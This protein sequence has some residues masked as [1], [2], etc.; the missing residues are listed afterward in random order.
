MEE[1]KD[2]WHSQLMRVIFIGLAS[3]AMLIPLEM[4]RSQIR[5]RERSHDEAIYDIT[6]SWGTTQTLNGPFITYKYLK[7]KNQSKEFETAAGTLFPD[8]L[9]YTVNTTSKELHRSIYDVQVYTADITVEGNFILEG[10]IVSSESTELALELLDLKGIQGNPEFTFNGKP[11]KIKANGNTITA[12]VKIPAGAAEGDSF[13]FC[14][15]IKINGSDALYFKPIGNLTT[16]D[17]TSDY[18]D[19]SFSGDFLPLERDV[20]EDGFTAKWEVSQITLASPSTD[21]FGVRLVKPVTQYRQTDR[22]LKYGILVIFLV[23]FAGFAVEMISR[24]SI[25]LIQY[26]VIGASLVLFYALLLAFSDFL[27]FSLSYLIAA[28]MTVVAL[29]AYFIAIV[30]GKWAYLLTA[31]VAI[32]YSVIYILLQMETFAFLAG[33]LLLFVILCFIMYLTRNLESRG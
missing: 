21:S 12:E 23:F 16:V 11:L 28:L 25:N 6:R 20:R 27:A 26:L 29:G 31:L 3:L 13:P 9:H 15:T 17:M 14:V 5:G 22:A 4:V 7:E 30:K 10:K 24:K 19:P 18:P 33:T 8:N 1:K 2:F 32:A